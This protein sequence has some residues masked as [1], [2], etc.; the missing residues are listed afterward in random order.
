MII[1]GKIIEGKIHILSNIRWE[2]YVKRD[3]G[4]WEGR[5]EKEIGEVQTGGG[6]GSETESET[7]GEG[8]P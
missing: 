7:E 4:D 8:K 3:L 1:E 5:G 2:D 6:D